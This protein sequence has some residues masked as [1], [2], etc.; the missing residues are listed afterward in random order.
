MHGS[1]ECVD[2]E[3]NVS[4]IKDN[5]YEKMLCLLPVPS[6]VLPDKLQLVMQ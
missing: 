3:F 2:F 1:C 4:R 6:G 5:L